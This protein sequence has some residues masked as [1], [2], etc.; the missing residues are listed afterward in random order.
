MSRAAGA[1]R[2]PLP[3]AKKGIDDKL[4]LMVGEVLRSQ[5][6]NIKVVTQD[7][8]RDARFGAIKDVNNPLPSAAASAAGYPPGSAAASR[9]PAKLS[10]KPPSNIRMMTKQVGIR[11]PGAQKALQLL[12]SQIKWD[13]GHRQ[14]YVEKG[15]LLYNV[16]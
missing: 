7:A 10:V 16:F 11:N 4:I 2:V 15:K 1:V 13:F 12:Q 6:G 9:T 5:M 8:M 14:F 3:S